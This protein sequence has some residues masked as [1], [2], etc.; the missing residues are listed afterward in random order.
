MAWGTAGSSQ[1]AELWAATLSIET[2]PPRVYLYTDSWVLYKGLRTWVTAWEAKE[3]A[4]SGRPLWGAPLWRQLLAF[5]R[6]ASLAVRHVE[7][8]TKAQ[9]IESRWNA[10]ADNMTRG[11]VIQLAEQYHV[12]GGHRG[13]R[14]TQYAA[15]RQGT[16]LPL[17][18]CCTA[19]AGCSICS[20]LAPIA[21]PE[22]AGHI[23]RATDPCQDWQVDYI[24]PL[25]QERRWQYVITAVDTYT[26]LLFVHP[27]A[28]AT[29]TTT[30][31]AL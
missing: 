13:A 5:A 24:G 25:P 1:W 21:L 14:A 20:R 2:A 23:Y 7:A 29:A 26:G 11:E 9:T 8:H 28:A 30:L 10:A 12:D 18:A 31:A 15:L 22:P 6:Q 27:S 4:L 17:S 3:W 16:M 19:R